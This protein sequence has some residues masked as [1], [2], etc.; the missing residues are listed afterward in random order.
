M[1]LSS[2]PILETR[3][4]ASL[5]EWKNPVVLFCFGILIGTTFYFQN[6]K[7]MILIGLCTAILI[8]YFFIKNK[9]VF[10]LALAIITGYFYTTSYFK[11]LTVSLDS[12]LN[13]RYIYVGEITS[14][15][16]NYNYYK[17]YEL[18]LKNIK[19]ITDNKKWK[20]NNCKVEVTGTKYEEYEIGDII[21]ITGRVK[22]PKNAVLP[23]LFDEEKYLLTQNINYKL[24]A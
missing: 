24:I 13:E 12:F 3:L 4:I 2:E 19:S 11:L 15:P 1:G 22:H 9:K 8:S 17:K 23:G 6:I 10:L 16:S 20:L 5:C 14:E 21:Q 18:N 7:E